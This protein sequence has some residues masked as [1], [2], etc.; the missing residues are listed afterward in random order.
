[1]EYDIV[2]TCSVK[3]TTATKV[4]DTCVNKPSLPT[5]LF[6]FIDTSISCI[7]NTS[8]DDVEGSNP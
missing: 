7:T 2:K 1:M 8:I 6:E 4:M 5:D 3:T